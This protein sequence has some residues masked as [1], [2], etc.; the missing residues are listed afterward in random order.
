MATSSPSHNLSEICDLIIAYIQNEKMNIKQMMKYL[1]GPDIPTG[2]IIANMSDLSNIYRTGVGK[3]KLRGKIVFEKA[4]SS[5]EK[6]KLVITEIPYT[7]IG[8]G[9]S[10]FMADVAAL[11]EAKK[12]LDISEIYNHSGKE[13]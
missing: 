6:D 12:I 9:I 4:K 1:K 11:C 2:G 13:E 7:M 5:K 3:L 8:D 10:K